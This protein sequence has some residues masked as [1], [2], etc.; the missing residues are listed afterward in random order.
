MKLTF[1]DAVLCTERFSV[2]PTN[3]DYFDTRQQIHD[4]TGIP[5]LE[6]DGLIW[7]W[8]MARRDKE[9]VTALQLLDLAGWCEKAYETGERSPPGPKDRIHNIIE[10]ILD[11]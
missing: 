2:V 8:R 7:D 3:P 5:H 10:K 4:S 6:L 1:I 11:F 9:H